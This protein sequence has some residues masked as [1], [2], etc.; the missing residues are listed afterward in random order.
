MFSFSNRY[1]KQILLKDFGQESQVKLSES[2]VLV[3][4]AGGLGCPALQYLA[5]VGIGTIGIVDFDIIAESNLQRQ[6]LYNTTD[7]GK[8]KVA[9]VYDKLKALNT[10]INIE[11]FNVKIDNENA[12]NILKKFD[13]IIDCSD[14]FPTRYLINDACVLLDKPL[15]FGAVMAYEGQVGVFN[16]LDSTTN[17]KT[18]YRDLF[19]NQPISDTLLSCNEVGVLG[20][21]TG[22]IGTLQ[23]T[24]AIKIITGIGKVLSNKVFTYSLLSNS[25]YDFDVFPNNKKIQPKNEQE[26]LAVN[27]DFNCNVITEINARELSIIKGNVILIDIRE[28]HEKEV[29]K[30]LETIKI[31][32]SIL[33]NRADGLSLSKKTVTICKSGTRS[34]KAASIIQSIY[35]TIEV[36]SLQGG[37][38][39]WNNFQ[40]NE[41]T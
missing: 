39:S 19:P 36:F 33:K 22:I 26:Y 14:N 24:E 23:A 37:L 32:L 35:P 4:G 18:N 25:F 20:V 30:D 27:Y 10:A 38:D 2:K 15:I 29:I 8:L 11:I 3:I 6:I 7:I 9:V 31:P 17:I 12:L 40:Q 21:L 28:E 16:F 34:K 13:I 41:N 5:A 1:E